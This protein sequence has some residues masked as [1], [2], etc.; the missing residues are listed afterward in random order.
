M[1]PKIQHKVQQPARFIK[2][3]KKYGSLEKLQIAEDRVAGKNQ[4]KK[5]TPAKVLQPRKKGS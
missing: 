4:Y 3:R 1:P 5:E 2:T